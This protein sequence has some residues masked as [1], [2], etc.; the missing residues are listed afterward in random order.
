MLSSEAVYAKD[1][2][3]LCMVGSFCMYKVSQMSNL[4]ASLPREK[5]EH[6]NKARIVASMI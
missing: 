6:G 3:T 2:G 5:G 4:L 1:R